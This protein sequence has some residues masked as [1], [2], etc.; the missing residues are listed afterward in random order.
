[1]DLR[2]IKRK[3]RE[4]IIASGIII[5]GD[6]KLRSNYC[7]ASLKSISLIYFITILG[8]ALLADI[9]DLKRAIIKLIFKE[10]KANI[11]DNLTSLARKESKMLKDFIYGKRSIYKRSKIVILCF[12]PS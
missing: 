6:L 7:I 10:K 5:N 9:K 4:V 11:K 2:D 8:R 3:A 1:L 12:L